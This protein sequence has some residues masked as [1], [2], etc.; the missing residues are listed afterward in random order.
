MTSKFIAVSGL[1]IPPFTEIHHPLARE[2]VRELQ[3]LPRRE[4]ARKTPSQAL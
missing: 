4:A 1:H 3:Q 2:F